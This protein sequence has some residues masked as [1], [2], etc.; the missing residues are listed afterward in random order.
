MRTA[1]NAP[2]RA[3][4]SKYTR[5]ALDNMWALRRVDGRSGGCVVLASVRHEP[6][7]GRERLSALAGAALAALAVGTAPDQYRFRPSRYATT[8]VSLRAY[9]DRGIPGQRRCPI[10]WSFCGGVDDNSPGLLDANCTQL[11]S[12]R[13]SARQRRDGGWSPLVTRRVFADLECALVCSGVL[14]TKRADARDRARVTGM[15]RVLVM[16]CAGSFAG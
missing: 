10:V 1:K 6:P 2:E 9:L 3:V 4:G 5:T 15:R 7:E 13:L 12:T 11:S 16:A 8:R 14:V